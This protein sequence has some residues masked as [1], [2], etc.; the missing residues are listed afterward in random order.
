MLKTRVGQSEAVRLRKI[1]SAKRSSAV[2]RMLERSG[3]KL[4]SRGKAGPG[5]TGEGED[6]GRVSVVSVSKT[7]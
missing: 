3:R 5:G 4:G 2:C 7:Y 6:I 1:L